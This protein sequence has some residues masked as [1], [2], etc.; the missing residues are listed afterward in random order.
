MCE[1]RTFCYILLNSST[2]MQTGEGKSCLLPLHD[3]GPPVDLAAVALLHHVSPV[4]LEA[5]VR[6]LHQPRCQV[7]IEYMYYVTTSTRTHVHV[8]YVE[9]FFRIFY[10]F[11]SSQLRGGRGRAKPGIGD[12]QRRLRW[13]K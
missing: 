10:N 4:E 5:R 7:K 3:E 1:E 11:F 12:T 9:S 6:R 8:P 2:V 13:W